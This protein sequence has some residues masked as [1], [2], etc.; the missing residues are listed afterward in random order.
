MIF[1][2]SLF[3][4][5]IIIWVWWI[6]PFIVV[7]FSNIYL[8]L[9]LFIK[10]FSFGSRLWLLF[11]IDSTMMSPCFHSINCTYSLFCD[12]FHFSSPRLYYYGLSSSSFLKNKFFFLEKINNIPIFQYILFCMYEKYIKFY[13]AWAS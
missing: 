2:D 8:F 10:W 9:N 13:S 3:N 1:I 11:D 12:S 6:F 5:I 7:S 4:R